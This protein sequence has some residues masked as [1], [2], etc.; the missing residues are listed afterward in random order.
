MDALDTEQFISPRTPRGPGRT[1]TVSHR[2]GLSREAAWSPTPTYELVLD[3]VEVDP[4][5]LLEQHVDVVEGEGPDVR[6]SCS[7]SSAARL[8]S[9]TATPS[10]SR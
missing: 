2:Q 10:R 3:R 6:L 9:R 5:V 7:S 1:R 4:R 8:G